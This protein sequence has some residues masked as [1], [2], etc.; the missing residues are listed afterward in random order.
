VPPR[1]PKALTEAEFKPVNTESHAARA[2]YDETRHGSCPVH[3]TVWD[4]CVV[5]P[6]TYRASKHGHSVWHPVVFPNETKT[7][8]LQ[9][10]DTILVSC[11]KNLLFFT[12]HRDSLSWKRRQFLIVGKE[13][14]FV[15]HQIEI[16]WQ[17]KGNSSLLVNK[18]F[19]LQWK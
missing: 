19:C 5:L 14:P 16:S 18:A 2:L 13:V 17:Q 11:E 7:T 6:S 12:I 1:A 10:G 4:T 9:S 8:S 3:V 15:C